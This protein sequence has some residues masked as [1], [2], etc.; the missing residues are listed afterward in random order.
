MIYI[1]ITCVYVYTYIHTYI[2][3]CMHACIHTYIHVY[4]YIYICMCIHN[5]CPCSIVSRQDD[6]CSHRTLGGGLM[7]SFDFHFWACRMYCSTKAGEPMNSRCR[8]SHVCRNLQW[9]QR[10]SVNSLQDTQNPMKIPWFIFPLKS[11]IIFIIFPLKLP[12]IGTYPPFL[13]TL[14]WSLKV[15]NGLMI[16]VVNIPSPNSSNQPGTLHEGIFPTHAEISARMRLQIDVYVY[17]VTS[18]KSLQFT[19][20]NVSNRI[21]ERA[22]NWQGHTISL[23]IYIILYTIMKVYS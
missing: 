15:I 11:F 5:T 13:S 20:L 17:G 4:I 18:K 2:H 14:E 22:D 8:D 16:P 6:A 19:C 12:S 1:Y 21:G 23:F 10:V 3:A 7:T 9:S